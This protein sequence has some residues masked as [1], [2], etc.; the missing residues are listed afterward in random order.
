MPNF[1]R[2]GPLKRERIIGRGRGTCPQYND[3]GRLHPFEAESKT[4]SNRKSNQPAGAGIPCQ[5]HSSV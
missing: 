2:T 1:E 5:N 4:R 3:E